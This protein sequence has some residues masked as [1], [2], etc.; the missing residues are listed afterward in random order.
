MR[1]RQERLLRNAGNP[2]GM[3]SIRFSSLPSPLACLFLSGASIEYYCSSAAGFRQKS[4]QDY[5]FT[6]I[7]ENFLLHVAATRWFG[8]EFQLSAPIFIL[9]DD[10]QLEEGGKTYAVE[11]SDMMG[12]NFNV[13]FT[14]GK[15]ADI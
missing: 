13:K 1:L 8:V 12:V 6:A 11:G 5:P 15:I 10:L 9:M 14:F 2:F 3:C 4:P 7:G